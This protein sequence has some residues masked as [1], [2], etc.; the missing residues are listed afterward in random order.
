MG[1]QCGRQVA[2]WW[3]GFRAVV[4]H[5]GA[6]AGW[7][8]AV[9]ALSDVKSQRRARWPGGGWP[10]GQDGGGAW[11]GRGGV[12]VVGH[13]GAEARWVGLLY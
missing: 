6:E 1:S 5:G 10:G 8:G 11:G 7:V 3:H 13:G 2:W 9:G 4:G 12:G